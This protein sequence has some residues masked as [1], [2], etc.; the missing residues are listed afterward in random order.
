MKAGWNSGA[1][2]NMISFDTFL[3]L[4]PYI[5]YNCT[6]LTSLFHDNSYGIVI[7]TGTTEGGEVFAV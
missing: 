4:D 1:F 6:P 2:I 7:L 5:V 3:T